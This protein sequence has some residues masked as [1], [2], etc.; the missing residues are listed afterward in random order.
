MF[1][2]LNYVFLSLYKTAIEWLSVSFQFQASCVP[3]FLGN[4]PTRGCFTGCNRSQTPGWHA[5][6]CRALNWI[7]TTFQPF[8]D[9]YFM[10]TVAHMKYI[11][12]VKGNPTSDQ[13]V[14]S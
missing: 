12:P 2:V 9:I 6:K 3:I 5:F 11:H 8:L 14:I 13:T 1:L 4:V 10:N 7:K